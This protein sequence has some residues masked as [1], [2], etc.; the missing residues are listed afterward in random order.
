M[1]M[2]IYKKAL[3]VLMKKPIKLWGISLLFEFLVCVGSA[4]CGIAIPIFGIA[5]TLL[6]STSM[7]LIFLHG[8]RG[9]EVKA[10]NLFDCF[11]DWQTIKRVLCG[12]G[13]M[14]L[15][16]FLWS[17]IPIVGWIFGLIRTYEYRLTP[18]ILMMEPDVKPTE[19]IKLSKERTKGWKSKMFWADILVFVFFF[20]AVLILGLLSRIPYAGILFMII[21]VVFYIVFMLLITLFLGL[22]QAAFYEEIQ[23]WGTFPGNEAYAQPKGPAAPKGGYKVP[24]GLASV[25]AKISGLSLPAS[26]PPAVGVVSFS[27]SDGVVSAELSEPVQK[28][29]I[30][31]LSGQENAESTIF[32]RKET[33]S[34]EAHA[35][36]KNSTA[37]LVRMIWKQGKT[38][39]TREY[40]ARSGQTGFLK[41]TATE[42]LDAEAYPPYTSAVRTVYYDESGNPVS[43]VFAF[44]NEKESFSRVTGYDAGGNLTFVRQSW[45]SLVKNG[46]ALD[47]VRDASGLLTALLYKGND[48]DFLIRSQAANE[49]I[50]SENGVRAASRDISLFDEDLSRKYLSLAIDLGVSEGFATPTDLATAT[51]LIEESAPLPENLRIW[52]LS[53]NRYPRV[54]VYAFASE[55]PLLIMKK[56]RAVLN[57]GAKDIKGNPLKI[58]QKLKSASPSFDL[59]AIE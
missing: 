22:V 7:T 6:L 41:F 46:Y 5:V 35:S 44:E 45:S 2:A 47:V 20:V 33:A 8:Y 51:D 49:N 9:E 55:D 16:I 57:P 52:S 56:N 19:A 53:Y 31:E 26:P 43:E 14:L 36:N 29:K 11:K 13:W 3:E 4:L 15:W 18:Y 23:K 12:M 21:L 37:F 28:M 40:S 58:S 30:L 25:P 48:S 10:V 27:V 38:E 24:D 34:A 17:L 42:A 39:F 50:F 1:I 54:T 59:V 32:S